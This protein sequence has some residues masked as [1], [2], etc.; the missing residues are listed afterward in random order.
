MTG[1]HIMTTLAS[2]PR[3]ENHRQDALVVVRFMHAE[4]ADLLRDPTL[5][6]RTS[7]ARRLV[8]ARTT[9]A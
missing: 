8:E 9:R 6:T 1:T 5:K 7:L 2:P 3:G 4:G